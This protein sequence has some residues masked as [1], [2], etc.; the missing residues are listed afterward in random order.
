MILSGSP[1][2]LYKLSSRSWA[3]P[4]VVRV[5]VQGDKIT[6]FERPWST[7][8]KIESKPSTGGMSVMRSIEQLANGLVVAAASI[9]I[10]AGCEG[11][12]LILNCWQ[13]PEP[14]TYFLTEVH[15]PGHQ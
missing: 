9:G 8:T 7:M 10:K 1:Y 12:W 5:F 14:L 11:E 3:A 2:H 6:P 13:G 4:S 15:R